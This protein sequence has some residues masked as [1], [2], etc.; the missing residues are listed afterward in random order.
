ME[1]ESR[2][3]ASAVEFHHGTF[4]SWE[5]NVH[6]LVLLLASLQ[7]SLCFGDGLSTLDGRADVA[8]LALGRLALAIE[9]VGG[10]SEGKSKTSEVE[11]A[12]RS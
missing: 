10:S 12:N 8:T 5:G 2:Q 4:R 6:L 7:A 3:A 1:S 9:V 11:T